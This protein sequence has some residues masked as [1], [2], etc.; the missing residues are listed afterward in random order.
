MKAGA[1]K[2]QLNIG[3]INEL[4]ILDLVKHWLMTRLQDNSKNLRNSYGGKNIL[5]LRGE[6]PLRQVP[7]MVCSKD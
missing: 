3:Y 1:A 6:P 5:P 4:Q 2:W 7:K